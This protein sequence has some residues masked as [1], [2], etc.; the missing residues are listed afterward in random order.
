MQHSFGGEIAITKLFIY[1]SRFIFLDASLYF[2]Q[3]GK[4]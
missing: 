1:L 2:I 3:L 4:N